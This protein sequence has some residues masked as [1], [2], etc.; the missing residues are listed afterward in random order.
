MEKHNN[1]L[2]DFPFGSDHPVTL[3]DTS[4][5]LSLG[6]LPGLEEFGQAI[7]KILP[8]LDGLICSPGQ[9]RRL[10]STTVSG[11]KLFVR[12]DWTNIL[13]DANFPLP[14]HTPVHL[15]ILDPQDAVAL[16]ASGMVV[17]LLLG[18]EDA[19]EAHCLK[20]IVQLALAGRELELPLIVEVRTS[21]PNVAAMDKAIELGASLAQE[22][23]ADTIIVSN[24]GLDSLKNIAAMLTVP[25]LLKPSSAKTDLTDCEAAFDLGAAGIWLDHTWLATYLPINELVRQLNTLAQANR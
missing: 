1:H 5:G 13:R 10:S 12:M 19:I 6:A 9:L 22:G 23:G 3:L 15:S 25:W 20:L 11:T 14:P 8:G 2:K 16:A 18:Y 7:P 24:P 21:G 4:G 17:D